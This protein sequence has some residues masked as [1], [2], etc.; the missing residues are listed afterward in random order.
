MDSLILNLKDLSEKYRPGLS[1]GAGNFMAEAAGVC[2]DS[3]K[4]QNNVKLLVEGIFDNTYTV[5]FDTITDQMRRTFG[6]LDVAVEYGAYGI[7]ILII[8]KNTEL[9]VIERSR[10]GT[11]FDYWLGNKE[12]NDPYFQRK[13]RLEVSGIRN[14]TER[15]IDARIKMKT[16][17]TKK[18]DG[19]L[20]AYVVVI[21]FGKPKAKVFKR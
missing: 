19:K 18:S 1:E 12:K 21:E 11:G 3:N 13:A 4:F 20:P 15:D 5:I 16:N 9:T 14:G 10:K 7:A 17:Q 8:D 2:F 6:D